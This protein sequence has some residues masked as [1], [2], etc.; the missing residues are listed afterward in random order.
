MNARLAKPAM[1]AAVLMFGAV[2]LTEAITPRTRLV[3]QIGRLE[4]ETAVPEA[5]GE[6]RVD[7]NRVAVVVNPQQQETIERIY[8]QT[9]SRTYV[10]SRGE[11]VMLSIAYGEDQRDGMQVHRP[12]VCYPAQGFRVESNRAVSLNYGGMP[13]PARRLET[14]HGG[15]RQEPVTYWITLA[16]QVLEGGLGKK[17][18]ELTYGLRGVIPDGLLFRLS[19]IDRNTEAAF[20]LQDAFA[21]DLLASLQPDARKRLVGY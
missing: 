20:A 21:R 2:A 7:P 5:F 15:Q 17:L 11:R 8:S 1:F 18:S 3:D 6:W 4:L 19:S 16:D 10:N 12:E 9:L 13:I 14:A